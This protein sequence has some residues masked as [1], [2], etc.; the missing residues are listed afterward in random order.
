MLEG[1]EQRCGRKVPRVGG[2]DSKKWIEVNGGP[3]MSN[4]QAAKVIARSLK[5]KQSWRI[6]L[7]SYW[8]KL[9]SLQYFSV[10]AHPGYVL[11]RS[12]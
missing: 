12:S 3:Q 8:Q 7:C 1:R 11:F 9:C 10:P 6:L 2:E 4:E 5:P